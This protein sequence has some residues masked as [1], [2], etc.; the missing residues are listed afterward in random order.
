[1]N[2]TDKF[3]TTL[4]FLD[5]LNPQ[6]W[7]DW[8]LKEDWEFLSRKY[9]TFLGYDPDTKKPHPSEWQKIIDPE[10]ARLWTEEYQKHVKSRG[11]DPVSVS[12]TVRYKKA[13]GSS[14]WV[15]CT[16]KV[17]EWDSDWNPVRMIGTHTDVTQT[18]LDAKLIKKQQEVFHIAF[19]KSMH[20]AALVSMDGHF[21]AANENLIEMLGYSAEELYEKT[22]MELTHPDDIEK[23]LAIMGQF[24]SGEITNI[25]QEKRYIRKDGKVIPVK[26]HI[27][28]IKNGI[29]YFICHIK[30]LTLEKE[31]LESIKKIDEI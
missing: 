19:F 2:Q 11:T 17:I 6:G 9:W 1:M 25:E 3:D 21:T 4:A 23:C 27:E 5:D 8:R 30:D 29:S 14:A 16:G 22:W 15:I 28:M 20:P 10:D 31:L 12:K 24:I 7:W 18:I 13:D 26:M